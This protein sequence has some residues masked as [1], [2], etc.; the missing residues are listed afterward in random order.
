MAN[1][2]LTAANHTYSMIKRIR[3]RQQAKLPAVD[4]KWRG[5]TKMINIL[6]K[7]LPKT[8]KFLLFRVISFHI[9]TKIAIK[10]LFHT[11]TEKS[12]HH[13]SSAF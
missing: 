1:I 4:K 7:V 11:K 10:C 6:A 8:Q 12:Y 13:G 5:G 9:H 2:L 3:S